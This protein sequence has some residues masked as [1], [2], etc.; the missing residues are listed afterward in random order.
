VE[1]VRGPWRSIVRA[2]AKGHR[3]HQAGGDPDADTVVRLDQRKPEQRRH[4]QQNRAGP[5]PDGWPETEEALA[6]QVEQRRAAQQEQVA[7]QDREKIRDRAAGAEQQGGEKQ[8]G[9]SH[10]PFAQAEDGRRVVAAQE[11]Q[12]HRHQQAQD[13]RNQDD[14]TNVEIEHVQ[15]LRRNTRSHT[16]WPRRRPRLSNLVCGR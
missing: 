15:A 9:G 16:P 12:H 13:A 2:W 11:E 10:R 1:K 5:E 3:R 6:A 7:D 14:G 8:D 4:C